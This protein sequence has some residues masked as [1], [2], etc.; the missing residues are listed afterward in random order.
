[1]HR[2]ALVF[3]LL[4]ALAPVGSA[5]AEEEE[6]EE[7]D[8]RER[9]TEREDKRRP[10]RSWTTEVGGRPL[11]ISGEL[12]L[13]PEF[14]RRR[15]IGPDPEDLPAFP[16]PVRQRDRLRME[17]SLELEGFYS[18]GESLS[19]FAQAKLASERD[20]LDHPVRRASDRDLMN[21]PDRALS[22]EFVELGEI[23]L[24]SENLLVD[25]LDLDLGRIHLEDERRWWWDDEIE[26]ARLQFERGSVAVS[27]AFARRLVS[28][29][30]DRSEVEPQE[31]AVA[32]WIAEVSWEYAESQ[33]LDLFAV[34][35]GDHSRT[36]NVGEVLRSEREDESDARLRWL[37]ARAT[38]AFDLRPRAIAGYWLDLAWLRG[39]E[40]L[41][42]Y[43]DEDLALPP[44]RSRVDAIARSRVSG[45]AHDA[46]LSLE[47]ESLAG[48]PR[49][50]AGHA[51]ATRA[52]RQVGLQNDEAGFGGVERFQRYG[53]LLDPELANLGV[54]TLGIGGS[55]LRSSS[56][57]LVFHRYRLSDRGSRLPG[58]E[59]EPVGELE[60]R[61]SD[62]GQAI[63]VVLAIEEWERFELE[64]ACSAFRAGRAFERAA[65]GET[66]LAAFLAL[67]FAF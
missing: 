59:L 29:H 46:G 44:R 5:R 4:I 30:L 25:G 22:D 62:L 13:K 15:V 19:A 51:R 37:G 60:P 53:I 20:L 16:D 63:D 18:F 56:L 45:F 31:R 57:D 41:V 47:L 14:V 21:R 39:R 34:N 12:E 8:L 6:D 52:F 65:R 23:W 38:G 1:M 17:S 27:L 48:Q 64:L 58:I 28:P 42:D 40:R 61:H 7:Q 33:R 66:S 9:L 43:D 32:R 10:E 26:G 67:R 3:A 54:Q 36:E 50:F 49:L 24:M 2:F 55:I 35:H 11:V